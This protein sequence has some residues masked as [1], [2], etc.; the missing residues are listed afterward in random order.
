[1][2]KNEGSAGPAGA[3]NILV[4]F[5]AV[6]VLSTMWNDQQKFEVMWRMYC[7]SNTNEMIYEMDHIL[8]CGY[9]IM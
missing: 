6:L 5:F 9:E 8:N 3:F 1:M 4:G 2:N 7:K